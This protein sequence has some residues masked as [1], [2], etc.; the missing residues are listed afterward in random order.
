MADAGVISTGLRDLAIAAPLEFRQDPPA[1]AEISLIDTKA[2]NV[3][4][5]HLLSLLRVPQFYDLDRLDMRAQA[6]LDA[7]SQR[8]V[9]DKFRTLADAGEAAKFGLIGERLLAKGDASGVA[10]SV[11]LY[12]RSGGINYLRVQADN[13]D[14]PLDLNEGGRFDLGSTAKLRTMVNYLEIIA[15]L[16]GRYGKLSNAELLGASEDAQDPLT[17]WAVKY[18]SETSDHRLQAMLDAAMQR[19]YSASP[20]EAFFTGRGLHVFANFDKRHNGRIMPVWEAFRYSVNLVFIRMMRDIVRYYQRGGSIWS[21]S[22]TWKDGCTST[23]ST[24][25]TA[26]AHPTMH[27]RC[28]RAALVRRR[29][30]WRPCFDRYGPTPITPISAPS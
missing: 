17:K 21:A 29:T 30:N 6:S 24:G 15:Q 25:A 8:L 10:Y 19:K 11:T 23:G 18:L 16:H 7:A 14:R 2:T 4:R 12:E 13:L 1:A 26:T 5:A 27:W 22:L 28:W 9:I 3:M 20:G